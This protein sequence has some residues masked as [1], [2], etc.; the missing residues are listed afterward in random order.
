[1]S[2]NQSTIGRKLTDGISLFLIIAAVI[3]A[4]R[5]L[6][7]A[8]QFNDPQIIDGDSI[9][10][11]LEEIRLHGIDAPEARQT[12]DRADGTRYDCGRRAARHLRQLVGNSS[13]D[14]Q[15]LD[16]DRYDRAVAVCSANGRE[17]NKTM[18]EDGWAVAYSQHS[19]AYLTAEHGAREAK[20]GIWQGR[21][22]EPALWRERHRASLA[23]TA[24]PADLPPD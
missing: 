17:L 24:I 7:P 2:A 20:R 3:V 6:T 8:S 14:C 22:E 15:I 1:M 12:C 13:L 4:V 16:T 10:D 19:L 23:G 18:V 9:R 11:G 5:Y 21:F